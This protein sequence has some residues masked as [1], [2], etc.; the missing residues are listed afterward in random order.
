VTV[1]II[2]DQEAASATTVPMNIPPIANCVLPAGI[3]VWNV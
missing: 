2:H 3:I 1:P